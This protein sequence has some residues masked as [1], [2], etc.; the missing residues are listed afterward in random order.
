MNVTITTRR[1]TIPTPIQRRTEELM[2]RMRRFDQ[3][4]L[5][6][7]VTYTLDGGEYQAEAR[8]SVAGGPTVVAR[9][10]DRTARG[11]LD[12]MAERLG[13]QLRRGRER[14]R[15]HQGPPLSELP[16]VAI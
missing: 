3:R 15:L 5:A 12:R 10:A 14:D 7:E 13:R 9:G 2:R 8:I 4:I 16:G 1:C 11:A 6:A